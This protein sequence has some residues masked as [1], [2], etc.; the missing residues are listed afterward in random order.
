MTQ[1]QSPWVEGAYGWSFGEGGWN[2]GMDSLDRSSTLLTLLNQ[3]KHTEACMQL[4]RWVKGKV[5]G[6]AITLR[7]L[8]TRRDNTMPYCLGDLSWDKQQEFKRFE[9]EYEKARKE[10]ET[11][12]P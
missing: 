5:K 6:K 2:V 4:T 11:K 10:L 7:G 9:A 1:Q 12:T 3:N 8:V